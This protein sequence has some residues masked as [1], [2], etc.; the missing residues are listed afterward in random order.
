M[1]RKWGR[2]GDMK[3]NKRESREKNRKGDRDL[4]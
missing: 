3:K 2:R 1:E 4:G